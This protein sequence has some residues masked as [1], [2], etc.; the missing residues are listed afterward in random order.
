MNKTFGEFFRPFINF[1][2]LPETIAQG[3]IETMQVDSINRCVAAAVQFPSLVEME[4]L[5]EA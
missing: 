4:A 3:V 1:E 5:Y 2:G